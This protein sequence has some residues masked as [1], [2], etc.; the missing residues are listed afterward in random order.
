MVKCERCGYEGT[1][2]E[3]KRSPKSFSDFKEKFICFNCYNELKEGLNKKVEKTTEV[4]KPKAKNP[5]NKECGYCGSLIKKDSEICPHC[6]YNISKK[7]V[8]KR[9]KPVKLN[10]DKDL[11]KKEETESYFPKT[12]DEIKRELPKRYRYLPMVSGIIIVVICLVFAGQAGVFTGIF[13]GSNDDLIY[14]SWELSDMQGTKDDDFEQIWTFFENDTLKIE[15]EFD[16]NSGRS[17]DIYYLSWEI[18]EDLLMLYRDYSDFE[19]EMTYNVVSKYDLRFLK[20]GSILEL[21]FKFLDHNL[22]IDMEL[23][24][25]R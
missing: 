7:K 3:V 23:K 25:K 12:N 9:E 6:N 14:G 22:D 24:K 16:D 20:G 2:K 4:I 10:P 8:F 15:T 11:F 13:E 21:T 18:S 17:F 1:N 5:D 19:K